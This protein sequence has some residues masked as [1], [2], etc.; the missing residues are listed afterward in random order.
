MELRELKKE[1]SSLP[2]LSEYLHKFQ[3]HWIKP[4]RANT[5]KNLPFLQK[6]S[7]KNKQEI[8]DNLFALQ[9]KLKEVEN[10]QL[11]NQKLQ[12]YAK[13]LIELKLTTLNGNHTKGQYIT[14]LLLQDQ[15]MNTT[16]LLHD[17]KYLEKNVKSIAYK[18][19]HLNE[20]VQK[21]APLE[22]AVQFMHLPHKEH[23]QTLLKVSRQQ[24]VL[25]KHLG[26]HFVSLA[27]Q[28]RRKK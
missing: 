24:K 12:E 13:Y 27:K 17:I 5:N 15:F 2:N 25:V 11:V 3:Q 26:E 6:I 4:I 28:S 22:E 21:E 18:Y 7:E 1:V 9:Q 19:H 10:A 8:N 16:N 20:L 14:K 23:L